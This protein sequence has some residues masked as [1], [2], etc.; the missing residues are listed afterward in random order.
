MITMQLA[1]LLSLLLRITKS[2]L[3]LKTLSWKEEKALSSLDTDSLDSD[4]PILDS[5]VGDGGI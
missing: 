1:S 5:P 4:V 2:S 3:F